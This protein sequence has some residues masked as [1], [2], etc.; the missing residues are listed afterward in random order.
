MVVE[1]LAAHG[2][3]RLFCVPGESYLALLDALYEHGEIDCVVCRHEG[4]AGFMALADARLT[5]LPGVLC[6]S[7]GPGAA[8]AAIAV[9]TAQQDGVPLIVIV[10]QV[11]ARDLRKG[12]FQEIDYGEMFGSTAKWTTEIVDPERV[13]EALQRAFRI[14]T[15]GVPGPVVVSIPEDVAAALTSAEAPRPQPRAEAA[16]SSSALN[17][18]RELLAGAER[19][20]VIAG[21]SIGSPGERRKLLNFLEEWQL[22]S[23]VS[24][25]RHDLLPNDHPLYAGDMGLSNPESQMHLL[26]QADLI[27]VLG[28]RL[29]DITTQNYSFP[30]RTGW[31]GTLVHVHED[32][33]VMGTQF[34]TDLAVTCPPAALFNA[35]GAP[36]KA[37]PN[38]SEWLS[39]LRR[40][41]DRI[42]AR[43]GSDVS[44]GVPFE[45]VVELVGKQLTADAV[46][47]L[48]AGMFAAPAY[49][50]IRFRPP[51]RLLAPIS[52][53]MG[54]G[55]PAAVAA[56]L[57][58]PERNVI[59]MV[60]DGG[61]LMTGSELAVAVERNLPL[62][63]IVSENGVYGS[64]RRHQEIDY[65]G[66][67]IGTSFRNPD[68][69]LFG[70]AYGFEVTRVATE[71]ELPKLRRALRAPGP[72]FV[73][74]TTSVDAI[75]P[76]PRGAVN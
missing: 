19:P 34:R 38:R 52:G 22:P 31:P 46:V 44:D 37:L 65:P 9:H 64:I 62:K 35:I 68:L 55:I 23:V 72:Q 47:T 70:E 56:K 40:E 4:G 29:G 53:A 1:S 3:D 39:G 58:K 50:L 12:A 66:R 48:D 11:A 13:G 63:V 14:A 15:S 20:L 33:S 7:R 2:I 42:A 28:S 24:F 73:I 74:V 61:L 32:P 75:L 76:A 21:G 25:R 67:S 16:P 8:N 6:V 59:C 60:G 43:N 45:L 17:E 10:G 27:V 26:K 30:P 41:R 69:E 57:R 5:G 36:R 54:F 49:R 18:L 51:Q 71:A